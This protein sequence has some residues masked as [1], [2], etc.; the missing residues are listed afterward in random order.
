[1]LSL[2]CLCLV[3]SA[4]PAVTGVK[5]PPPPLHGWC[6]TK[7]RPKKAAQ[8]G[9]DGYCKACFR[10][11]FPKKHATKLAQRA[12]TKCGFCKKLV[13]GCQNDVCSPC[14]LARSCDGC[15]A[16][17]LNASAPCCTHCP[18]LREKLGAAQPRLVLWCASCSSASELS[19]AMCRPCLR[20]LSGR[21]HHCEKSVQCLPQTFHCHTNGCARVM[22]FCMQCAS[23][24]GKTDKVLCKS[25]WHEE[26]DICI[27][28]RGNAAQRYLPCYRS[29]K[30]G[31]EKLLC[32]KCMF[33]LEIPTLLNN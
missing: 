12:K 7:H 6:R 5:S 28:C 9:F 19:A 1:M 18:E 30:A 20:R 26:G 2:Y 10:Q 17:N 29:C 31:I 11:Y 25:C 32:R 22:R 24:F 14:F 4:F 15:S 27:R 13:D 21:C 3:W 8:S 33:S 16:V 23:A